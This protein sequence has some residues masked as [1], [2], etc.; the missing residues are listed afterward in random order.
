VLESG[1]ATLYFVP[2]EPMLAALVA[3]A[4]RGADVRVLVPRSSDNVLVDLAARS[5]QPDLV[6]AGARVFEYGGRMLHAKT[7]V[8]DDDLA[9]VGTANFD[10]RS[11]RLNFEVVVAIYDEEITTELARAFEA[12]LEHASHVKVRELKDKK[13]LERLGENT[14]RL[15]SPLL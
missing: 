8:V 6:R 1:C 3:A 4:L 15:F 11:F 7:I 10:N 9:I 12:D 14:A 5:Y 2:D 13:L